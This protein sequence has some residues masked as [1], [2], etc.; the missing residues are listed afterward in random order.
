MILRSLARAV[1]LFLSLCQK[2]SKL[3]CEVH[4][5]FS[6]K[7]RSKKLMD[8]FL[9]SFWR[10]RVLRYAAATLVALM[11]LVGCFNVWSHCE[12]IWAAREG[13]LAMV[14]F[15]LKVRPNL[16]S[17]RDNDG[18]TPLCS[19][20]VAGETNVAELLLS[21]GADVN[22]GREEGWGPLQMA[23]AEGHIDMIKLLLS[24]KANV[25]AR[26]KYG[27]T[28]LSDAASQPNSNPIGLLLAYGADVNAKDVDGWTPLRVAVDADCKENVELLLV[29][30]ADVNAAD[31]FGRTPLHV[32]NRRKYKDI[33]ELLKKHGGLD[34]TPAPVAMLDA[35]EDSDLKTAET[36]LKKNPNLAFTRDPDGWTPLLFAAKNGDKSMIQLLITYKSNINIRDGEGETPLHWA[37]MSLTPK[38]S[39]KLLLANGADVNARDAE[40]KTP[41][42]LAVDY[43][44]RDPLIAELLLV[45]G[46]DVNVKDS[47][48]QTP[49]KHAL[50][51]GETD[52]AELLCKHGGHE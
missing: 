52:V 5:T 22:A 18:Y 34:T 14:K 8:P 48:G 38:D 15:L 24:K 20:A 13:N 11:A 35:A 42:H 51:G 27:D 28:P 41:L 43:W 29:S 2:F 12:V 47:N 7:R 16:I 31:N 40:G 25:N 23:I 17:V 19:A 6:K 46:A 3:K 36:L 33:A 9:K 10:S 21:N 49:Y 32:A 50:L 4:L 39:V 30:N 1:K 44:W 45:K 37:I 26:S